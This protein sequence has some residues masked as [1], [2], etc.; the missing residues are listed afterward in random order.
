MGRTLMN[1]ATDPVLD[2][3]SQSESADQMIFKGDSDSSRIVFLSGDVTENSIHSI[4]A[5]MIALSSSSTKPIYMIVSTYGGSVDEMFA[6][7]D[8]IKFIKCPV[9]TIAMGKVMSAGVL[10]LASGEKGKRLIGKN[11][12]IM[13]H[14]VSGVSH[15]NVFEVMNETTEHLRLQ[16]TMVEALV[17][18]T[19]MTKEQAEKIMKLGHDYY[20][21]A[22]Q[23]VEFGIVDKII[24]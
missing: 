2:K 10:L 21:T 4:I 20:L 23:A 7:Y 22:E 13:I 5:T 14:P 12:R 9:R 11:A 3:S 15:G 6:L 1:A 8:C 19:K 16:N 24:G 18:E 17:S